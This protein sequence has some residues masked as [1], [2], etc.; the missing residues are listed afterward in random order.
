M[1]TDQKPSRNPASPTPDRRQRC[2]H[3]ALAGSGLLVIEMICIALGLR[4]GPAGFIVSCLLIAPASM[5]LIWLVHTFQRL[6][7]QD[8]WCCRHCRYDLRGSPGPKCP[9][10]GTPMPDLFDLLI[11]N[12]N[13]H[14]F[15]YVINLL[16]FIFDHDEQTAIGH[17]KRI[18]DR[19]E[20]IVWTGT[21]EEGE[22]RRTAVLDF[23]P[24]DFTSPP[25]LRS[26]QMKLTPTRSRQEESSEAGQ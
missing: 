24:D 25:I 21:R 6:R 12:D 2:L 23:G 9:E 20:A 15:E 5:T 14:S 17:A 10:C 1:A 7:F 22:R 8:P 18:H 11:R 3:H 26:V 19:G 13:D 16:M 4:Q